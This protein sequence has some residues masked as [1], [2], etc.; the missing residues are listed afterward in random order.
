MDAIDKE[1]TNYEGVCIGP[2]PE[3]TVLNLIRTIRSDNDFDLVQRIVEA[4]LDPSEEIMS[5][6]VTRCLNF[7]RHTEA[8]NFVRKHKA[9][10]YLGKLGEG[11][12]WNNTYYV[13]RIDPAEKTITPQY[14]L[15]Y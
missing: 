7:G 8:T 11:N 6:Y 10:T 12:M 14:N 13:K 2:Y 5:V 3:A 1:N 4:M 9:K 15:F